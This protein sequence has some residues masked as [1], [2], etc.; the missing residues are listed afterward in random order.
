MTGVTN[1]TG[2]NGIT[3]VTG[4]TRVT[5]ITSLMSMTGITGMTLGWWGRENCLIPQGKTTAEGYFIDEQVV[6]TYM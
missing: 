1:M 4:M 3:K 2:M 5:S 6:V